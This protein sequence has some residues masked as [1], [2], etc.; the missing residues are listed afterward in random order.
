MGQ[1]SPSPLIFSPFLSM[2]L[3]LLTF[4]LGPLI[5]CFDSST[6]L[7]C[8]TFHLFIDVSL[9]LFLNVTNYFIASPLPVS[10]VPDSN[11]GPETVYID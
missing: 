10:E 6:V 8:F 7:H 3:L 1:F 2:P 9:C 4:I 11:L 5:L